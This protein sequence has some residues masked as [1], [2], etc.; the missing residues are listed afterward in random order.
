MPK[1]TGALIRA[2]AGVAILAALCWTLDLSAVADRL[3]QLS[4]GWFVVL[5]IAALFVKALKAYKWWLVLRAQGVTIS[6][7]RSLRLVFVGNFLGAVTP[8]GL[9]S[10]V[11]RVAALSDVQKHNEVISTL[12]LERILGYAVLITAA[13]LTLPLSA[14]YLGPNVYSILQSLI[15]LALLAIG[16]AYIYFNRGRLTGYIDTH[17][18]LRYSILAKLNILFL[19]FYEF[20]LHK[21]LLALVVILTGLEIFTL[22]IISYAGA[23]SLNINVSFAYLVSVIPLLQLV[24]RLPLTF[25]G[26]G[27]Q[28][29]LYVYL[30]VSAGF[31]ASEGFAVSI[32][33]R[34]VE[35]VLIFL[36]AFAWLFVKT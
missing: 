18:R 24:L 5:C 10:D 28:E 34:G 6:I 12:L 15:V 25:Y 3:A 17:M 14:Q 1:N 31:S 16:I 20:R 21:A 36:P 33:L 2:G 9:G 29:G 19:T 7:W 11:Y 27:I 32:L 22:I 4:L 26:L 30:L 8:A 23:H 13:A 35:I